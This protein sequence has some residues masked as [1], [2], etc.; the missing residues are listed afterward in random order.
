M[1]NNFTFGEKIK[2]RR[3]ELGMTQRC[4]AGDF[5]TRNMLSL[6][7]SGSA[8]PSFETADYLSKKLDIPL[9]YLFSSD[10]SLFMYEK[11]QKID[12]IKDLYKRKNYQYC[13][14]VID[15]LS[16]RDDELSYIYSM[17]SFMHG[18]K[19]LCNGSL[20]SAAKYLQLALESAENTIYDTDEIKAVCPLYLAVVENIQSPLLEFDKEIYD[21]IRLSHF[22]YEFYKYII[23]DYDYKFTS[24]LYGKHLE[25]KQLLKKYNYTEAIALLSALE[26]YKTYDYNACVLF[27]VYSDLEFCY[28][29]IGD[30]ENAYRYSAKRFSLISAFNT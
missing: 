10:T 14:S 30:F 22:D 13:M 7:E 17:C 19:M 20:T 6:I 23:L 12:Y 11:Q 15:A 16:D 18:K 21:K 4:V 24:E 26:E 28:K 1:N 29:Q 3:L 27:G 5:M 9:P 25:A 2:K 8:M